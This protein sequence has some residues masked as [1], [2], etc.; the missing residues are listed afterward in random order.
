MIVLNWASIIRELLM[1]ASDQVTSLLTWMN[2]FLNDMLFS[3]MLLLLFSSY[4]KSV[5]QHGSIWFNYCLPPSAEN[6]HRDQRKKCS[7]TIYARLDSVIEETYFRNILSQIHSPMI[8][9]L[10]KLFGML[11]SN[12]AFFCLT[13]L[14]HFLYIDK[15]MKFLAE[16]CVWRRITAISRWL[17][18]ISKVSRARLNW[19]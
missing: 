4:I 7:R 19:W 2:Q 15:G 18:Q 11:A 1:H 12:I 13:F 5:K 14:I 10:P 17:S 3:L 6:N 16:N 9:K 8:I